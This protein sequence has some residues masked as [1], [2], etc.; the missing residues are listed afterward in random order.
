MNLISLFSGAGGLLTGSAKTGYAGAK[1]GMKS[2]PENL[3]K[4]R[5]S[6]NKYNDLHIVQ[7]ACQV[8]NNPSNPFHIHRT[9]FLSDVYQRAYRSLLQ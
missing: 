5:A 6:N 8:Q 7:A 4:Q 1:G 2:L 9:H 3:S